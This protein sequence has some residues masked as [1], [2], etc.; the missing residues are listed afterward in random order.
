MVLIASGRRHALG[1]YPTLTL[2]KARIEASRILA[3]KTLGKIRPSH[4]AFNDAK[5]EFLKDCEGRV[6]PRTLKDYTRLLNRHYR[7]ARK[8]ITRTSQ[9]TR[10]CGC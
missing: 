9:H 4:K 6:R 7:F 8:S 10:S 3:E 2:S 1:R 5:D